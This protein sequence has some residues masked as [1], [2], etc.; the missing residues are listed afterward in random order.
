[1]VDVIVAEVD[2]P[3]RVV[4]AARRLRELGY[5][6]L[7]AYTPFPIAELDGVLSIRRTRLP[8]LV[9]A[10]GVAGAA[11][12]LLLLWWTNAYDYPLN[13]GGRPL[14]S[15][16]TDVPIVFET[17]VLFASLTAF[18]SV[19]V[20]SRLPRLHD[21]LFDLPGFERTRIDRFWIVVQDALVF[22]DDIREARAA[23]DER[24]ERLLTSI[25]AEELEKLRSALKELDAVVTWERVGGDLPVSTR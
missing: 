13:V 1:M 17:A 23:V 8:Y 25:Q 24:R 11:I 3:E 12:A 2:S 4:E 10:G 16:P 7:E 22:A 19:L 15:I 20:G 14:F 5:G 18:A 9:L 21:P 6:Q